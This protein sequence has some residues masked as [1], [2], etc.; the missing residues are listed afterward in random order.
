MADISKVLERNRFNKT[1]SLKRGA[2]PSS[3]G[4]LT[5]PKPVPVPE[6]TRP[7]SN[8]SQNNEKK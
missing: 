2:K 3:A 6:P 5:R 7:S 1:G 4:S 8:G